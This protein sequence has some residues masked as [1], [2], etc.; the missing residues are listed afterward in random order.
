[1]PALAWC[2]LAGLLAAA[3][4]TL[5]SR[6]ALSFSRACALVALLAP[7]LV[8][9][10]FV[11]ERFVPERRVGLGLVV[12]ALYS[13][14]YCR[15]GLRSITGSRQFVATAA[16]A[17]VAI[18]SVWLGNVLYVQPALWTSGEE[19]EDEY[20]EEGDWA[21]VEPILF[22]Q[23]KRIDAAVAQFVRPAGD[24][25]V[26]FFVG[27]AGFGDQKVFAEEIEFAAQRF[28]RR[29]GTAERTLLLINDRRS[30]D[31]H[32]LA[33]ATALSYALKGV[34]SKMDLDR[35]ILFLALSSHGSEDPLLSVTNGT[36]PLQD[37]SGAT[38][39][40]ALSESGIK[41]KV[42]VISA[43]HA[44]AF[45]EPLKDEHTILITAAAAVPVDQEPVP[46][47]RREADQGRERDESR[48]EPRAGAPDPFAH[49]DGSFVRAGEKARGVGRRLP[50]PMLERRQGIAIGACVLLG[51]LGL[52]PAAGGKPDPLAFLAWLALIASAAGAVTGAARVPPLPYGIAVPAAWTF[53]LIATDLAASRHV[54]T[55][56][57]AA[58]AVTGSFLVGSAVGSVLRRHPWGA[59]GACML[60]TLA[61][62][63]GPLA[64]MLSREAPGS[65]RAH[66]R[67][68]RALLDVSPLV[69][70]TECA[71]LDWVHAHPDMYVYS[72][73]EWFQRRPWRGPL[74]APAWLVVGCVLAQAAA[75]RS[76]AS[77]KR[78]EVDEDEPPP[79][80]PWPCASTSA[81][82]PR[83]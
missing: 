66:P 76:R 33:S 41:W 6:P 51:A 1:L 14:N 31:A 50:R 72:G 77:P 61:L 15:A 75:L 40:E 22:Q 37:L 83:S 58:C 5:I 62:A 12:L 71:G 36:L 49:A 70:A 44:G 45:I 27:F 38:L 64:G 63:V 47:R 8:I 48:E 28:A 55:P 20:A 79:P 18:L 53:G 65:V 17:A 60:V 10:Q 59:A 9:G 34:A 43:C 26:G 11:I 68:A 21:A 54:P 25:P 81:R 7:V 30:L 82:S 80:E 73:V 13:T 19:T 74:A 35:D 29:Y 24:A 3:T 57:W 56:A 52:L 4:L 78:A 32:P 39:A 67:L 42:I 16:G 46:E 69:F 23:A 2:V